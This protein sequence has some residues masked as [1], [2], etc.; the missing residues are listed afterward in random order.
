MERSGVNCALGI[1]VMAIAT[2]ALPWVTSSSQRV[3]DPLPVSIASAGSFPL[4][5]AFRRVHNT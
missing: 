4:I 3:K 1:C 2:V 5:L